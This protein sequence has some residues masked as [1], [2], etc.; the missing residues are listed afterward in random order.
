MRVRVP[1]ILLKCD[2]LLMVGNH[3]FKVGDAGSSPVNRTKIGMDYG[4]SRVCKTPAGQFES[5]ASHKRYCLLMAGNWFFK[6]GDA[7]SSPVDTTKLG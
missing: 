2:C 5:D 1:S 7:G 4:D 3:P 6:P